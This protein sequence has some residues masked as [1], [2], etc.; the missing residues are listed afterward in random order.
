[1]F[2]RMKVGE[3][4]FLLSREGLFL[5]ASES[6]ASEF[7]QKL[8]FSSCQIFVIGA[9]EHTERVFPNLNGIRFLSIDAW[10]DISD[11][12][13]EPSKLIFI[14]DFT[15][16][17]L[18]EKFLNGNVSRVVFYQKMGVLYRTPVSWFKSGRPCSQCVQNL[19]NAR[20]S[21]IQSKLLEIETKLRV[22]NIPSIAG[23]SKPTV[24]EEI[25]IVDYALKFVT[26][27]NQEQ[28]KAISLLQYA[29]FIY[30][31][32]YETFN[33]LLPVDLSCAHEVFD[34]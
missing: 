13:D 30:L 3:K 9:T 5:A 28:Q 31:A 32:S 15:S 25:F 7:E 34:A 18:A 19:W 29:T 26:A 33:E 2:E 16:E 1:M 24:A 14:V 21:P 23:V 17:R 6:A 4:L 11:G 20:L 8:D 22:N 12:L 10:R 27:I